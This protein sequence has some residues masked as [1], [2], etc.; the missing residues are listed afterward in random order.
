MDRSG[1][2]LPATVNPTMVPLQAKVISGIRRRVWIVLQS[3]NTS[4]TKTFGNPLVKRSALVLPTWHNNRLQSM[5]RVWCGVR[6]YA[7]YILPDMPGLPNQTAK[8]H[9]SPAE[10]TTL[11]F[12]FA[13]GIC[14]NDRVRGYRYHD[15]V[16]AYCMVIM[17]I[18]ALV[19]IY[20]FETSNICPRVSDR[21]IK[22]LAQ[23]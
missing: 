20:F 18:T 23:M 1:R 22:F 7:S 13:S 2:R 9:N 14:R 15:R 6:A 17:I 5:Y 10:P 4:A 8:I 3:R 11:V 19:A 12:I 21:E 16:L